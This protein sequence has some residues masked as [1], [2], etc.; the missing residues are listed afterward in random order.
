[1]TTLAIA[2]Q[3][4]DTLSALRKLEGRAT[5]GDVV[6][7]TGI[8]AADA[9]AS[10]KAL[11]ESHHGHLAVSDSGELLYHFDPGLIRRGT[12]PLLARVKRTSWEV[13]TKV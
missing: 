4:A 9:K 11:L 13:L 3:Q 10:L 7:A 8:A 1:M 5:I 2:E 6:T 12:E